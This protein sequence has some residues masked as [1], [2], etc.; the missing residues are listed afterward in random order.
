MS[1]FPVERT[2]L[3]YV[4]RDDNYIS[5]SR[6]N[7]W[8][9][10]TVHWKYRVVMMITLTLW[11]LSICSGDNSLWQRWR[12]YTIENRTVFILNSRSLFVPWPPLV[13][14]ACCTQTRWPG[15]LWCVGRWARRSY[16]SPSS[17]CRCPNPLHGRIHTSQYRWHLPPSGSSWCHICNRTT[18]R[19]FLKSYTL[20]DMVSDYVVFYPADETWKYA[21][22]LFTYLGPLLPTWFIFN[23]G[24]DK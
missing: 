1:I 11:N 2:L 14:T 9:A 23:S 16:Y 22:C 17:G 13:G 12:D 19:L 3:F 5:I 4:C 24:I 10:Q 15:L 20:D 8:F 6:T 7:V 21:N 18:H